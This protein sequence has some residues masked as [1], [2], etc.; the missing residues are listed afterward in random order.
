MVKLGK[1]TYGKYN[2]EQKHISRIS[3]DPQQINRKISRMHKQTF[4]EERNVKGHWSVCS[5]S[6]LLISEMQNKIMIRNNY[7]PTKWHRWTSL[8]RKRAMGPLHIVDLGL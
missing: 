5:A 7:M 1:I 3:K 4:H 8:T 2:Q 6:L